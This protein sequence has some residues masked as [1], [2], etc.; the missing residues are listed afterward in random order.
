MRRTEL[1]DKPYLSALACGR[2]L[3]LLYGNVVVYVSMGSELDT[4]ALIDRLSKS[5]DI[6]L[7]AP[8]TVGDTIYPL[9]LVKSGKA[10]GTGNL[11]V[12]CYNADDFKAALS[13]HGG[14]APKIDCC[15]T[16]L[17]GINGDGY[18]I[19]YGKGC[20][21][22]FFHGNAVPRKIGLAF[23]CQTCEFTPES[24]DVPLDCC[25][26]DTKVVYFNHNAGDCG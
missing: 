19:G 7:Y 18:R 9:R 16:P 8:F 5:A 12:E 3:P 2:L 23:G 10:D 24:S 17:L 26:F 15:V 13:P 6:T 4:S 22:R 20:Y 25:V 11:P 14:Y 1:S 21:D